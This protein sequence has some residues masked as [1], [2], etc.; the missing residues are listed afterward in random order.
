M[1]LIGEN[2][3]HWTVDLATGEPIRCDRIE[4]LVRLRAS[5]FRES[6]DITAE[7]LAQQVVDIKAGR[8]HQL[9][10]E[11]AEIF[12]EAEEKLDQEGR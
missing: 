7:E 1:G 10:R 4:D 5:N 12:E 2:G 11:L 3:E 8:K 6:A 9:D